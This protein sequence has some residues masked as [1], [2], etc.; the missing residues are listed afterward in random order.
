MNKCLF[1]GK[2]YNLKDNGKTGKD[3]NANFRLAV[4]KPFVT[5][6]DKK[7]KE[8][9]HFLTVNG[10]GQRA[11]QLLQFFK[12]GDFIEVDVSW[13][14]FK[15]NN[16]EVP[17]FRLN[18]WSF[19]AGGSDS[20]NGGHSGGGGNSRDDS[21][22]GRDDRGSSRDDRGS[23]RGS[24]DDDRNSRGSRE[25]DRGSRR[26][27]REEPEDDAPPRRGNRRGNDD[28]GSDDNTPF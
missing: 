12:D 27:T 24:R 6:E 22:G 20:G 7:N 1:S 25:D 4:R 19:P 18:D 5:D 11:D 17:Q 8:Y 14:P 13:D 16:G 3:A 10:W 2:I 9:N 23:S 15:G 26:N 21:R 28:N